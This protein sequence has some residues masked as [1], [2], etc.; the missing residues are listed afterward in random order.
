MRRDPYPNCQWHRSGEMRRWCLNAS[1]ISSY[2]DWDRE[3]LDVYINES[4]YDTD[5]GT[6]KLKMS[7]FNVSSFDSYV[8]PRYIIA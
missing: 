4:A 2:S 6:V 7:P 5:R 1:Q 8:H 3:V